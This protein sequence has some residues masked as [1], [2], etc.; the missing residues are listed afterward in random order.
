[1][2]KIKAIQ[3][4]IVSFIKL[5]NVSSLAKASGNEVC[6]E[7]VF[8]NKLKCSEVVILKEFEPSP[9]EMCVGYDIEFKIQSCKDENN[10]RVKE[11]KVNLNLFGREIAGNKWII[12]RDTGA[13]ELLSFMLSLDVV[14]GMY[15]FSNPG[16]FLGTRP[17][18][19]AYFNYV[20]AR[21]DYSSG[22]AFCYLLRELGLLVGMEKDALSLIRE[23]KVSTEFVKGFAKTFLNF[24]GENDNM[25][26]HINKIMKIVEILVRNKMEN[27][28]SGIFD[29]SSFF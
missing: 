10:W 19:S 27:S 7:V 16:V 23:K 12:S 20:N 11:A 17:I 14:K 3:S 4:A 9:V 2:F 1:M 5:K 22:Q 8:D 28:G 25:T 26:D 13:I 21:N 24:Y 15:A 6:S 29:Y 18:A